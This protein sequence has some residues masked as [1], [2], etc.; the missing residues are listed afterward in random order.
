M[1]KTVAS[2]FGLTLFIAISCSGNSYDGS[3][4]N[5]KNSLAITFKEAINYA[6]EGRPMLSEINFNFICESSFADAAEYCIMK[7]SILEL[8]NVGAFKAISKVE[9]GE[10]WPVSVDSGVVFCTD[11]MEVL[12]L[13][14]GR[15][16]AINGTATSNAEGNGYAPL[17]LIWLE[18]S[19]YGEGIMKNISPILN[20]GLSLKKEK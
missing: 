10:S 15:Y 1:N 4:V 7:D 13:A 14:N 3:P 2:I 5:D 17:E 6:S 8:A 18:D 20:L 19:N 9:M 16:Y 11:K 12:F